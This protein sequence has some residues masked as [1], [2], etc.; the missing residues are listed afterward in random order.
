MWTGG[1]TPRPRT[2]AERPDINRCV[3]RGCDAPPIG[4]AK[5]LFDRRFKRSQDGGVTGWRRSASAIIAVTL[6]VLIL[7][8]ISGR[9]G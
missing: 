9:L 2:G 6:S 4:V 7:L 8:A 5:K 3:S 1:R